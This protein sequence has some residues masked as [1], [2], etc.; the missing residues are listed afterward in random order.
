MSL[1]EGLVAAETGD[2]AAPFRRRCATQGRLAPPAWRPLSF[3]ARG[4][5]LASL[6]GIFDRSRDL[7]SAGD[8]DALMADARVLEG[9][10]PAAIFYNLLLA[11]HK[12]R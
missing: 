9:R 1:R 11:A 6:H 8:G 3:A 5:A 7:E 4:R 2:I 10:L 12:P